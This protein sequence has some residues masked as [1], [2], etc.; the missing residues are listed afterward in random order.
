VLMRGPNGFA[1]LDLPEL[2]PPFVNPKGI[3]SARLTKLRIRLRVRRGRCRQ[4]GQWYSLTSGVGDGVFTPLCECHVLL[5]VTPMHAG[6]QPLRDD[7]SNCTT[8]K[9]CF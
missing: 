8:T 5:T 1:R 7:Y 6:G 4:S 9:K 3:R 2:R